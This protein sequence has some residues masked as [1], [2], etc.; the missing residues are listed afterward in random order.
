[1]APNGEHSDDVRREIPRTSLS[2]PVP[3]YEK[4]DLG[5]KGTVFDINE[6][7]VGVKGIQSDVGDKKT[8]VI[9]AED[10]IDIDPLTFEAECRWVRKGE[11]GD[12]ESGHRITHIGDKDL[13]ELRKWIRLV[14]PD[15]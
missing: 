6:K 13:T 11:D 7:G 14:S 15:S 8:F 9:I 5:V 12:C 10:H 3:I 2:Y 1:M 4:T